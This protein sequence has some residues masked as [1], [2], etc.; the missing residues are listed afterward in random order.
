MI[1]E[2]NFN[3]KNTE[4]SVVKDVNMIGEIL[5]AEID[6]QITT[7][8]MYPRSLRTFKQKALSMAT[9][10]VETAEACFY[11]LPRSGKTVEGPSIRLAE[12]CIS[13]WGNLRA[14][15]NV[16]ANDRKTITARAYCHDLETNTAIAIEVKRRITDKLGR[17]Y[18]EDMQVVTGNAACKIALRNA[19]FSVIPMAYTKDIYEEV[20]KV[21]AGDE[22]D[23]ATR[24]T[25]ALK[26]FQSLG[27]TF[28]RIYAVLGVKSEEDIDLE[29]FLTLKGIANA[30]KD[31]DTTADEAFPKIE[32]KTDAQVKAESAL[33][34]T[35]E[36]IKANGNKK[37][38]GK[39]K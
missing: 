27:I 36:T 3:D 9:L 30:I 13:A 25:A 16:I 29:M 35:V 18:S 23:L 38:E 19:V 31:G 8:K 20:R 6:M 39:D 10:D 37:A 34:T 5:K 33:K 24:R 28:D 11:A 17:T 12:I 26:Y 7:A 21:A 4:T 14:S 2:N 32:E 22:K 15:A 1:Q